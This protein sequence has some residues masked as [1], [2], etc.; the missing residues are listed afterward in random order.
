MGK[1]S[2]QAYFAKYKDPRWQKKR[3]EILDRD[4]WACQLCHDSESPLHVHHKGYV[5]GR[6]P[7]AYDD[8]WLAT[9]C[10]VCHQIET[11]ERYPTNDSLVLAF[12]IHFF[13]SDISD[14]ATSLANCD[15]PHT[16]DVVGSALSYLFR[17][18]GELQK[19][20]EAYFE[21]LGH[22]RR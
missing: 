3:L 17:T 6:D 13:G 10:E 20:V 18:P 22:R 15:L 4:E 12:R 11:D 7:W 8:S 1:R 16:P 14:I 21:H 9:V 2:K 5:K 19:V